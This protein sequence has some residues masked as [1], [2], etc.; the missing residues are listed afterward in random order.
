MND[1]EG[2]PDEVK[3]FLRR[4][5]AERLPHRVQ[6]CPS[7]LE[8]RV[9]VETGREIWEV[10]FD[11]DGGVSVAQSVWAGPTLE[12][13]EALA[14]LF[15]RLAKAWRAASVDLG[16]DFVSPFTFE[17]PSGQPVSCSG[18]LPDFGGSKGTVLVSRADADEVDDAAVAA[19]FYTSGLNPTYYEVYDRKRF[20][21]TL[22]EWGWY[23]A[24]SRRPRW[25]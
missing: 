4:L 6:P 18:L 23:G 5:E 24:S 19:G 8:A 2:L 1:A 7:W 16:F 14:G 17:A 12:G 13:V 3:S 22:R 21:A 10:D 20:I 11:R 15:D 25:L 9:H